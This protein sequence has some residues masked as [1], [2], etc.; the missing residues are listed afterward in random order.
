MSFVTS[1]L[2]CFKKKA[3]RIHLATKLACIICRRSGFNISW[4]HIIG[5]WLELTPL[6]L[7]TYT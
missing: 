1:Q 4:A 6:I 7:K 3:F 5:K 2:L